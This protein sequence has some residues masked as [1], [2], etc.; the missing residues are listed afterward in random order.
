MSFSPW[1]V[2]PAREQAGFGW[3]VWTAL[4]DAP[5]S[6]NNFVVADDIQSE[7]DAKLMAAAPELL[8]LARQVVLE[9]E[10][11]S[12]DYPSSTIPKDIYNGA[13][14]A[15]AKAQGGDK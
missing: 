14:K 11:A 8:E 6:R 15:I 9:Y 12:G 10:N 3:Q 5:G 13:V 7:D 1:R 4:D 2:L